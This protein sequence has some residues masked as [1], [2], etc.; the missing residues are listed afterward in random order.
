MNDLLGFL[1]GFIAS[2]STP[3][4]IFAAGKITVEVCNA[5]F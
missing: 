5:V 4:L 2:F 1:G 3:W